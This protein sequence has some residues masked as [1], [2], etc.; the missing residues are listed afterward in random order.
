[1]K[2]ENNRQFHFFLDIP[3]ATISTESKVYF[4]STTQIRSKVSSTL[5]LSKYKW[6]KSVDGNVFHF[7]NF[8]EIKRHKTELMIP[9]T[10]FDD[11]RHYRLLVWNILG[12]C[13]SNTVYLN[14]I[15]SM[16]SHVM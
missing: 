7:I 12:G 10:T 8:N 13:V 16:F 15:G 1:M 6:Q 2:I 11:I 3:K 5:P 9:S 14:V 4:G